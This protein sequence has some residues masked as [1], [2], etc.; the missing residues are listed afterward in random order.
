MPRTRAR[1]ILLAEIPEFAEPKADGSGNMVADRVYEPHEVPADAPKPFAIITLG[2]EG[3]GGGY[4]SR[5]LTM[6]VAVHNDESTF[7]ALSALTRRV[8]LALHGRRLDE[9]ADG[10]GVAEAVYIAEY[11]GS[12]LNES[13]DPIYESL[14]RTV[15]FDVHRIDFQDQETFEPDPISGLNNAMRQIFG[16]EIEMDFNKL[17]GLTNPFMYWRVESS[18]VDWANMLN[19]GSWV[20]LVIRGHI[21]G[22]APKQ[23]AEWSR[24]IQ[25][26][27][28]TVGDVPLSDGSPL[29]INSVAVDTSQS[30][31]TQGQITM[32]ARMGVLN[33]Q[34]KVVPES[35][36]DLERVIVDSDLGD[37]VVPEVNPP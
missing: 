1:E 28:A 30:P 24:R 36:P 7:V 8:E 20:D 31:Y 37:F 29:L 35:S 14:T 13:R 4:E 19:W 22:Q 16:D 26:A 9:D 10:D 32:R 11:A 27:M 5:D 33:E 6:N 12:P 15:T 21:I 3:T 18:N 23:R 34:A 2:T 25:Q 17:Q